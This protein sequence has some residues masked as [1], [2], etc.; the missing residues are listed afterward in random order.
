MYWTPYRGPVFLEFRLNAE[1]NIERGDDEANR[2]LQR[3]EL[4]IGDVSALCQ[5]DTLTATISEA[6]AAAEMKEASTQFAFPALHAALQAAEEEASEADIRAAVDKD[7]DL[8]L[9]ASWQQ[10]QAK[11]RR[12]EVSQLARQWGPRRA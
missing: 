1:L 7:I 2:P 4:Q 5:R 9:Q 12:D 6:D 3:G 10:Q 8:L 11:H